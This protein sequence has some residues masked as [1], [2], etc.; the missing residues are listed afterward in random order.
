[1][2][3]LPKNCE[4][5]CLDHPRR[6]DRAFRLIFRNEDGEDYRSE[7]YYP[8]KRQRVK[9]AAYE[10]C[11]RYG[12]LEFPPATGILTREEL[13]KLD[14]MVEDAIQD[15]DANSARYVPD[16]EKFWNDM[17]NWAEDDQEFYMDGNDLL[18]CGDPP[19]PSPD[20]DRDDG[21]TQYN[22]T[23]S[24]YRVVPSSVSKQK[25]AKLTRGPRGIEV[26]EFSSGDMSGDWNTDAVFVRHQ[27]GVKITKEDRERCFATSKANE[28][29]REAYNKASQEDSNYGDLYR[30]WVKAAEAH[31]IA[32]T[33]RDESI[34][35]EYWNPEEFRDYAT[36][37]NCYWTLL[38]YKRYQIWCALEGKDPL[39][40]VSPI[41]EQVTG[42]FSV[43]ATQ[44]Q[45]KVDFEVEL[46]SGDIRLQEK[47]FRYV[48]GH[49]FEELK[50]YVHAQPE[51]RKHKYGGEEDGWKPGKITVASVEFI[52]TLTERF[53]AA[54]DAHR[55]R[56]VSCEGI[57]EKVKRMIAEIEK[58]YPKQ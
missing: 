41:T 47:A 5:E 13:V 46:I 2:K 1:M 37:L 51:G 33:L 24:V 7:I 9:T 34:E 54:P 56:Q 3:K 14:H 4:I 53:T 21:W 42:T 28:E 55:I 20:C 57:Q 50:T 35:E 31:K 17:F 6:K 18:A 8:A 49:T 26:I 27:K 52:V 23:H 38:R 19:I 44:R 43:V 45:G 39:G 58:R 12:W 29:A 48:E 22:Y 16:P 10:I 32:S 30:A 11:Q 40:N 25:A 36:Q 15:M